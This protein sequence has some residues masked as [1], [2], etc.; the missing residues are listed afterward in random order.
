MLILRLILLFL[1]RPDLSDKLENNF[2][3]E[4]KNGCFPKSAF[5]LLFAVNKWFVVPF[6]ETAQ[7]KADFF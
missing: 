1:W 6:P 4:F 3:F 7:I 2:F 5:E